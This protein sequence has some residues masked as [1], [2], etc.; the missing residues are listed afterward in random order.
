MIAA[1]QGKQP[2]VLDD[3]SLNGVLVNGRKVD[4]DRAGRRRRADDRPLPP[5]PAPGL[6]TSLSQ[7]PYTEDK[8]RLANL[9]TAKFL[10]ERLSHKPPGVSSHHVRGALEH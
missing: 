4:V 8:D 3:R 6:A 10:L 2:R 9:E 7:S 1:E 5:L